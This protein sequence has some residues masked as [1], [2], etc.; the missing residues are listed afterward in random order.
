MR[1]SD[2]GA[3]DPNLKAKPSF[4]IVSLLGLSFF[5]LA[6]IPLLSSSASTS[7]Y[8]MTSRKPIVGG[9]FAAVLVFGILAGIYPSKCSGVFHFGKARQEGSPQAVSQLPEEDL[10]LQGHHPDCGS[11]NA[12]IFRIGTRFYCAGCVGLILGAVLSLTGALVYFFAQISIAGGSP[13]IFWTGIA[14]VCC[15][16]LQYHLFDFG[17]SSIHM[18]VNTLF[19]FS[20]FILL[21]WADSVSHNFALDI[22]LIALSIFWL[23]TRILLSRFD[24]EE[25]CSSCDVRT[26][27]FL[28]R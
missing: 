13:L 27:T 12:H 23:Y 4:V 8:G 20:V 16:L 22:Y 25:T 15:G 1:P 5:G 17:K 24:H 28:T 3:T 2:N 14:G 10:R 18:L 19:V 6:I 9:A 11:F 7:E 21:L 26:C